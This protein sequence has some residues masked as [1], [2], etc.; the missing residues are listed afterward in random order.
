MN[1]PDLIDKL[2]M[3]GIHTK[4]EYF[5]EAFSR[6]LGLLTMAE[7][8]RL[9]RARIA[10][11]GMGGVGG[12]H[13][14]TMV[15]SGVGKFHI[16]D[17][18]TFEPVN[19]NRQF[20]ARVPEFG[21]SK[22][23][24]MTEQALLINPFL[25]ISEFPEGIDPSNIDRFLE[26]VD[27]VLDGLDFF[28]FDIRR[29]LF[30][31]ARE[32]GIHVVTAA[33]LGFS[34]ALL[35]FSPDKGMGFDEYFDI[36]EGMTAEEQYLAFAMGLAPRPTH[37][38]YMDLSKV[39]LSSRA[40][41]SLNVSCQICTG[42]AG[43]EALRIILKRNGLKPV[44]HYVQFD[45]FLMKLRK[46]RLVMGNRNPAQRIK[47]R[48]VKIILNRNRQQIFR[49]MPELPQNISS[50]GV[51]SR[52]ALEFLIEAGC[53]APSGDNA[54]PWKFSAADNSVHVLL[55]R[56]ADDS[57]FNV[58]Q[59]A[60][61]ISCGAVIENIVIAGSHLDLQTQVSYLS[62]KRKPD[63]MAELGFVQNGDRVK[64]EKKPDP[65]FDSIWKRN[66]NRKFYE[67]K[68]IPSDILKNIQDSISCL[69]GTKVCFVSNKQTL[70]QIAQMVYKADQIRTQ[71]RSLHEHL[72][73]MIR[74]TQEEAQATRDGLP[75]KNLE[76]G[77][78]GEVFLKATKAWKVMSLMNQTGIS[79]AVAFHSFQGIERCS[80][81]AL[82]TSDGFTEECFLTGGRALERIWL[83]FTRC[84]IA[85]QPMTAM[86]LFWLRWILEGKN[87]FTEKQQTMLTEVWKEFERIFPQVD[88][89]K[90]APVMLLRYGKSD[91]IS[92]GTLRKGVDCFLDNADIP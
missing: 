83:S 49:K 64:T 52:K 37:V 85:V 70:K 77:L 36:V 39:D 89:K 61:I 66:T 79:K 78:A 22:L 91:A 92:Y 4:Q 20:G 82:V 58:N 16:S 43:T 27:V 46:G 57:F 40:G 41:P 71:N 17:F 28:N 23:E 80:G 38:K 45:P 51:L 31:R 67:R 8:E 9:A 35:I 84:K 54:Q 34:A 6:N 18:D 19:V 76:A 63:V 13:L 69:P 65:L 59:I 24:T 81:V 1:I 29:L 68:E 3:S 86:T 48:I 60:S 25:E 26:D 75:L 11:P 73:K 56:Q 90:E 88:M 62:D 55:D 74:F 33:P 44:P 21:R 72:N 2:K 15:R 47:T 42:M 12:L 32:K 50:N 87:A 14:I 7:Q 5:I 53:Q 10:I 30:K